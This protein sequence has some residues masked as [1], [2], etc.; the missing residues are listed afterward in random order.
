MPAFTQLEFVGKSGAS[1]NVHLARLPSGGLFVYSP[2]W[3]GDDTFAQIEKHGTPEVLFAPNAYHHVSLEK[4]RARWPDA[5]ACASAH[6]LERLTKKGHPGLRDAATAPLPTDGKLL[7]AESAGE[8][9]LK[10]SDELL[11]CDAFANFTRPITGIVGLAMKLFHVTGGVAI[12]S[13]FKHF[14]VSDRAKYKAWLLSMLD[15][16]QP[17]T[18]HF[19]HGEP[20]TGPDVVHRLET[21]TNARL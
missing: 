13:P 6:S 11:V 3:L 14:I 20:I 15:R 5:I 8:T 10:V 12:G 4:F 21:A 17:K 16:E 7:V 18:I 9:F 19:S 1:W 2:S